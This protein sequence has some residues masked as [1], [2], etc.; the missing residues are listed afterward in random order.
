M[1]NLLFK[2]QAKREAK[3]R[4]DKP[5]SPKIAKRV[6]QIPTAALPQWADQAIYELGR[7]MS[8]Y[9][10]SSDPHLLEEAR[11]GAEAVHAVIEAIHQRTT[12]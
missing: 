4:W 3:K 5:F 10:R 9:E 7:T 8:A 1:L 12:M 6:R 11:R 2:W